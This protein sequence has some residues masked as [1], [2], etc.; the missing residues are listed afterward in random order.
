MLQ[1]LVARGLRAQVR[2]ASLITGQLFIALRWF[3][4]GRGTT[5]VAERD[6]VWVVP[7][8]LGGTDQIQDQVES[9][10][11][12][13]DKIPFDAIGGDARDAMHAATSLLGHLD[14]EVVPTAQQLVGQMAA[15][16]DSLSALRDN[17]A[18]PDSAIQQT[19]RSTLEQLE[20]AARSLRG[21]TDY[22][23]HHPES[24]LRGRASGPEPR[25][26]P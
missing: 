3:S 1:A 14:R 13:I 22:L 21:L 10:V 18:A 7:T 20:N 11:A 19:T 4:G 16:R 9:I 17:V 5:P 8:E 26:G 23:Q 15:L 6:G 12:K 2:S 24:I 25:G